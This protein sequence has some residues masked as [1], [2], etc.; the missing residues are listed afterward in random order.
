MNSTADLNLAELYAQ[1]GEHLGRNSVRLANET[2]Q[3]VLSADVV[4]MKRCASSW[5][6]DNTLRALS[7][8]FSNL[9]VI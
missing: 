7:E 9:L 5:A 1:I 8:N 4:V 3:D 2:E 6:S